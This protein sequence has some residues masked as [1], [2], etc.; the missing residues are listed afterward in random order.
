MAGVQ[1]PKMGLWYGYAAEESGINLQM[2]DNWTKVGALMQICVIDRTHTAPPAGPANGDTY[3][4]K[5]TATGAWVGMENRIAVWR[6]SA[7]AWSFYTPK[8]GW[9]AVIDAEGTYGTLTVFKG[10]AWSPGLALT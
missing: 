10:S 2:D 3:I 8:N 1:D 9:M 5:A 4:V 6:S 7:A